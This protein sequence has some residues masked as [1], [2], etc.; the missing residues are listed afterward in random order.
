M[1]TFKKGKKKKIILD[2]DRDR[3]FINDQKGKKK[4]KRPKQYFKDDV[5]EDFLKFDSSYGL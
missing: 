4:V 5:D 1:P 3:A 2:K